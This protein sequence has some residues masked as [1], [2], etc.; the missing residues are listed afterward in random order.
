MRMALGLDIGGSG[1]K[2]ALVDT[3]SGEL[4][5][6][7]KRVPTPE[8]L[9]PDEVLAAAVELVGQ[10]EGSAP[11][12]I[13]FPAVVQQGTPMTPFSAHQ[14][15]S[16]LGVPVARRMEEGTKRPTLLLNDADAAGIAEMRF[17]SGRGQDGLVMILTLG[18]GIGSALFIDGTLVPNTELGHLYLRKQSKVAEQRAA[19]RVRKRDKLEWPAYAKR[20]NEYLVHLERIFSPRLFIL[21]GGVSRKAE[22]FVPLLKVRAE[23]VPAALRNDAGII[24]AAIAASEQ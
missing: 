22:K 15:E 8:S 11:L 19:P 23:V 21:G 1:I 4:A 24:G 13:G 9:E 16:W 12:G 2:G 18:T 5:S 20:L 6:E 17:G 14:I 3:A 7:R 10:F